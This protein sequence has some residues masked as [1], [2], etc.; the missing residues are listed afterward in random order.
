MNNLIIKKEN[1]LVDTELIDEKFIRL[2]NFNKQFSFM[3]YD[4]QS[5]IR[6]YNQNVNYLENVNN[7]YWNAQ[8]EYLNIKKN[9]YTKYKNLL[10]AQNDLLYNINSSNYPYGIWRYG[11]NFYY[12]P[13]PQ[14]ELCIG[15]AE[16]ISK[17][18][19]SRYPINV[20]IVDDLNDC[21]SRFIRTV[22]RSDSDSFKVE[23]F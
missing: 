18:I 5:N 2:N 4:F 19:S 17:E 21:S 22:C 23:I 7:R 3:Q 9:E 11:D 13:S 20:C 12:R 8:Y 14:S 15:N 1:E 10:I 6:Q 16:K